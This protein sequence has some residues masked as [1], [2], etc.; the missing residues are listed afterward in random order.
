M[1]ILFNVME[2]GQPGV[3]GG[4]EKKFYA[5]IKYD[6]EVT[7][8][9]LVKEIE[10]FSSLSEPDI[11][12]VIIALEN[13]IQDKLANSKI[14]R[15]EKLGNFYP[16]IS[17]EGVEKAEN[18]SSNNIKKVNVNYRPGPRIIK[19]LENAGFKKA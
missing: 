4:G 10:K 3:V 9:E 17:S 8:D 14:V 16:S 7:V 15:L 6:G 13:T 11:R 18:F 19:A 5:A 2:K 1:P 12:G